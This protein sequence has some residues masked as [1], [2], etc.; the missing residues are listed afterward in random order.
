MNKYKIFDINK[1]LLEEDKT[2]EAVNSKEAIVKY[3]KQEYNRQIEP[4]RTSGNNK[5]AEFRAL[6]FIK[7][8]GKIYKVGREVWYRPKN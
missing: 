6:R 5:F 4:K 3:V 2:I 7:E 8:E 1:P